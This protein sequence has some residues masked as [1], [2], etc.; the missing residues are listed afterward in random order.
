MTVLAGDPLRLLCDVTGNPEPE[1]VTWLFTRGQDTVSST[2]ADWPF[3]PYM[4][5]DNHIY[6]KRLDE[7]F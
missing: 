5:S 2:A 6:K 1:E 3:A 4:A 7:H